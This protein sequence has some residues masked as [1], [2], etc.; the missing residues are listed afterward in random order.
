[1][2]SNFWLR[3]IC[4]GVFLYPFFNV[5]AEPVTTETARW[6]SLF[7]GRNLDSWRPKIR[8]YALDENTS[9]TFRVDNGIL[10]VAYDQYGRFDGQFGH[11]FYEEPFSHYR[12]RI[13]YRFK[14]EQAPGG[15]NWAFRNS[16]VMIHAQSPETMA[17]NQDFPVSLEVQFLGG[18]GREERPTANLCTP[19][20]HVVLKG[21]LHKPHC[22]N[23]SSR[24]FHGEDWVTVEVEVQ[25]G[26]V[27]RHYVNGQL[28][29][30]YGDPQYDPDDAWGKR[31]IREGQ[32]G[33][34]GG[35]IAL[36]AES[37][38]VEFRK[39]ELLRLENP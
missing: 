33:I 38:P 25:G 29:M 11:L 30:E 31:Q 34:T 36:Q 35:Y 19:G 5:E 17:H 14:G 28:V 32:L 4:C 18:N 20:T 15:P 23:S 27:I 6:I 9:E 13:E 22:T 16:G 26:D 24:T 37:A 1:M 21:S 10:K 3:V 2:L 12:L 8:G 7:N 39:V